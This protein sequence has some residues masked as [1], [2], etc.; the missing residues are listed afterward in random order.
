MIGPFIELDVIAPTAGKRQLR[1]AQ[2][3]ICKQVPVST[4]PRVVVRLFDGSVLIVTKASIAAAGLPIT[5]TKSG[6]RRVVAQQ[7]AGV[8][9]AL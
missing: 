8:V 1:R 9:K 6:G 2:I 7:R 4:P 3:E 5:R